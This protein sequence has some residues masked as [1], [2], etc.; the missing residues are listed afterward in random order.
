M[1]LQTDVN[2][3]SQIY[4]PPDYEYSVARNKV[5]E[6]LQGITF[7]EKEAPYTQQEQERVKQDAQLVWDSVAG[8]YVQQGPKT[9][10]FTAGAPGAGKTTLLAALRIPGIPYIDF[11]DVSLKGMKSTY[12][13]ENDRTAHAYTKWRPGSHYVTHVVTANLWRL[14]YDFYFGTTSTSPFT[15]LTYQKVKD[16]GYTLKVIHLSAPDD[17][18]F[19]STKKREESWVQS[20]FEDTIEKGKMLPQ[21]INDTFLKFADE[22]DFYWRG[23]AD[24]KAEH[25]ATWTRGRGIQVINPRLYDQVKGLHN[26][27]VR[28]LPQVDESLLWENSVELIK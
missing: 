7:R 17:A 2:N 18:R 11:D 8:N 3:L 6:N 28:S 22:I 12:V 15:R 19:E 1:Q 4:N 26:A 27:Q 14:G 21:R 25:A 10:T 24:E 16:L 20:T 5:E 9:A 13:A 23:A